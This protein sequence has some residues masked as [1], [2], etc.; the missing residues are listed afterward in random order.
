MRVCESPPLEGLR[1]RPPGAGPESIIVL[2]IPPPMPRPPPGGATPTRS[3]RKSLVAMPRSRRPS[4][5]L[6]LPKQLSPSLGPTPGSY[7]SPADSGPPRT[8]SHY[9]STSGSG[10]GGERSSHGR[11]MS[12]Q[13][14]RVKPMGPVTPRGMPS[15]SL[16]PDR[17]LLVPQLP[18]TLTHTHTAGLGSEPS[19]RPPSPPGSPRALPTALTH[20]STHILT[21]AH[22]HTHTDSPAEVRP[23]RRTRRRVSSV[24]PRV[25]DGITGSSGQRAAAIYSPAVP[26]GAPS[27]KHRNR[28]AS[29]HAGVRGAGLSHSSP[30]SPS[31]GPANP[32]E[33]ASARAPVWGV[34]LVPLQSPAGVSVCLRVSACVCV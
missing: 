3:P 5:A 12:V 7:D 29:V 23:S 18:R 30:T 17:L 6:P 27:G 34:R 32:P 19:S 24:S 20:T 1:P 2:D 15:H 10:G 31:I 21:S 33:Q 11:R 9:A 16:S 22:A 26:G 25:L 14:S 8:V 4:Q 13:V 28:H